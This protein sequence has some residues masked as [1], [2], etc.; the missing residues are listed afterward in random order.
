MAAGKLLDRDA[1]RG[2]WQLVFQVVRESRDVQF[3]AGPNRGGVLHSHRYIIH[4]VA[5][6]PGRRGS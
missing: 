5:P 2:R 6:S 4:F 3:F 1:V